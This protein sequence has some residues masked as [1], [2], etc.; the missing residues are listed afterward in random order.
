MI[1]VAVLV[2]GCSA[3]VWDQ[4]G[5]N[6][7][8]RDDAHIAPIAT[9]DDTSQ[10]AVRNMIDDFRLQAKRN[11]SSYTEKLSSGDA[12]EVIE[13]ACNVRGLAT[14]FFA[15]SDHERLAFIKSQYSDSFAKAEDVTTVAQ[16][17]DN[18]A[19]A[20]NDVAFLGPS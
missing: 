14:F 12:K 4:V 10:V 7:H 15:G 17:V 20:M 3:D 6:A 13:D 8:D 5:H 11:L 1:A 16:D 19:Q 2:S 18:M 9:H